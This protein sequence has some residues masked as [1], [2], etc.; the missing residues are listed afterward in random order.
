MELDMCIMRGATG[1]CPK[2]WG[3]IAVRNTNKYTHKD[4]TVYANTTTFD[5]RYNLTVV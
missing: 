4:Y 3:Y 2:F 5:C 1:I